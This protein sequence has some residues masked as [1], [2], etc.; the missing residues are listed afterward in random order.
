MGVECR[1]D[2]VVEGLSQQA[3]GREQLAAGVR[4][5]LQGYGEDVVALLDQI[6]LADVELPA[7]IRVG[8]P[9]IEVAP[10][11]QVV[12]DQAGDDTGDE[13]V[14]IAVALQEVLHLLGIAAHATAAQ[15]RLG[16]GGPQSGQPLVQDAGN[17]LAGRVSRTR[18]TSREVMRIFDGPAA[19][20]CRSR[21]LSSGR[22]ALQGSR[23]A[24]S[25]V[26]PGV[27]VG[28]L[29]GVVAVVGNKDPF[30]AVEDQQPGSRL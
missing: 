4:K 3:E 18:G 19:A 20:S 28:Q 21:S 1:Q 17:G 23:R 25:S 11:R 12:V 14:A 15:Q 8:R 26:L 30:Q 13:R 10:V 5:R 2:G 7:V 24:I 22:M 9:S 29:G 16:V 6:E 27:L